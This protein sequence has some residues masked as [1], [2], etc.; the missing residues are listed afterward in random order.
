M[1]KK[2]LH[3]GV[4]FAVCAAVFLYASTAKAVQRMNPRQAFYYHAQHNNFI[5]LQKLQQ[6]GY[7]IDTTDEE[8]NTA[9]CEAVYK[10]DYATFATLRQMGASTSHICV[11]KIP[12]QTIFQFNQGYHA[13]AGSVNSGQI[14]YN[15]Y[16]AW[17]P[18]NT[19]NRYPKVFVPTATSTVPES[20]GLSTATMVGIGVG[21]AAVVGGAVALLTHKGGGK[22]NGAGA[23]PINSNTVIEACP[24]DISGYT[25]DVCPQGYQKSSKKCRSG[26]TILYKCIENSCTGY[27]PSCPTE[28]YVAIPACQK[29][30]EQ[31]YKCNPDPNCKGNSTKPQN[32]AESDECKYGNQT[33]YTCTACKDGWE[34]P[35]GGCT[36]K[37][38]CPS[39]Y[40]PA[41][42]CP[43]GVTSNFCRHGNDTLYICQCTG[44]TAHEH[45]NGYSSCTNDSGT[46]LYTC[47]S[48]KQGWTD[49][50]NNC[51]TKNTCPANY[52]TTGCS[53][54]E[55]YEPTGNDCWSDKDHYIECRAKDCSG[56]KLTGNCPDGATCEPC[57][58]AGTTTK[59][60]VNCAD[61]KIVN[62]DG[63]A[64]ILTCD[65]N[66]YLSGNS[67]LACPEHSTSPSGSEGINSCQCISGYKMINEACVLYDFPNVNA[68][69]ANGTPASFVTTEFS[70]GGF[71]N[72]I[73]AQYAYARGYNGYI[74][75]RDT[76]SGNLNSNTLT[77]EKIKVGVWDNA[78]D[79]NQPDLVANI[80]TRQFSNGN[81]KTYGYNTKIGPCR[82][83]DTTNCYG[84]HK[85]DTW[86]SIFPNSG[87]IVWYDENGTATRLTDAEYYTEE[88]ITKLKLTEHTYSSNYDWDNENIKY[89]VAPESSSVDEYSNMAENSQD[90]GTH[91]AGIVGATNNNK[92]MHGVVPNAELYLAT[93]TNDDIQNID[94]YYAAKYFAD[95]GV[96]VVNASFGAT[97]FYASQF[98][99]LSDA[100]KSEKLS[101]GSTKAHQ[102]YADNNIVLVKA[103]GNSGKGG[104][105]EAFWDTAIP[106]MSDFKKGGEHD[107]TNLFV[108]VVALDKN[109]RLASYSQYCGVTN[110]WCIAAPGGDHNAILGQLNAQYYAGELT[111]SEYLKKW[112]Q[113]YKDAGIYSTVTSNSSHSYMTDGGTS[114]GYSNGTSMAAPVVTGSIALLMSAYPHLTSQ[115][116]VEILFRSANQ[117]LVGWGSS[118]ASGYYDDSSKKYIETVVHDELSTWTDSFGHEYEL[119]KIYG[120]GEVDLKRATEPFGELMT[121]TN[122]STSSKISLKNTKLALPRFIGS[123]IFNQFPTTVLALDEYNRPFTTSLTGKVR[124]AYRNPDSFK[125]AFKAFLNP[126]TIQQAGVAD[127][128]SFSFASTTTDNDMLGFGIFD[129]NYR[130][131]DSAAM[132]FSYRSDTMNEIDPTAKVL[133]NPFI[134]MTDSYSLSQ[135]LNYRNLTFEFGA[136]MGKNAFYETDEDKED[137]F[138][139]SAHA[140]DTA[141]T[142]RPNKSVAF[143][144]LG[145]VMQEKE[146]LLGI[147][148]TGAF[149]T[150]DGKTYFTG[151]VLEYKPFVPFTLS[152]NYYYGL[153]SMP[154]T[155]GFLKIDRLISD[156]FAL[157]ARYQPDENNTFGFQFSSPLRIRT[158]NATLN[159][160]V[161][162]DLYNDVVYFQEQKVALK[163]NAREYDFG[164]Y[165][166]NK[167]DNYDWRTQLMMRLHPDHMKEA[168]PDYRALF[169]LSYKY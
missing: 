153:S 58:S 115:Q 121:P 116:I 161:A 66:Q 146:A 168:K 54:S 110:A 162:R 95:S 167:S 122:T 142:Y 74:A 15:A 89:N 114:Y 91:V 72:Q 21:T 109:D 138:H 158:G 92:G 71:L 145:G 118:F 18:S 102:I 11:S 148:G 126:N 100:E 37:H 82:N 152:A 124:Q 135:Q 160:P 166:M 112:A 59:K 41:S 165:Y 7:R 78:F 53:E 98:K 103:A 139:R 24:E 63:T 42:E 136:T 164:L 147:N 151:A 64:C 81:T 155:D 150:D 26:D 111:Y 55:G 127:K 32:C 10:K 88:D 130:F 65:E 50:S 119:S 68:H 132:K 156:S 149:A 129:M 12:P 38:T 2:V 4:L 44:Q 14:S 1:I 131:N 56:Y 29:G 36:V 23:I 106:L 94:D 169:G 69:P 123:H 154:K 34:N 5:A 46:T 77:N 33:R 140:F 137:D 117:N 83:G 87:Y 96:R 85:T 62:V 157:D 104:Q 144:V 84:I 90:H 93:W 48:C 27:Y 16:P 30:S 125:R 73:N 113:A 17:S 97:S 60:I 99:D 43:Q 8:G 70:K 67:C 128:L 76:T 107:L 31:Y 6:L 3:L 47:T 25:A 40:K 75:D 86:A 163:P 9:L 22:S 101:L 108:S 28:G 141:L 143:K 39:D 159:L 120:H 61:N 45:C 20:T 57:I 49:P 133:Q 80:A 52:T 13:W 35:T 19:Q 79:V 51:E 105:Y 134:N